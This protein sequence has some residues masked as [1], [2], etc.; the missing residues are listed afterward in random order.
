MK[1]TLCHLLIINSF[2]LFPSKA[3]ELPL[4]YILQYSQDFSKQTSIDDFNFSNPDSCKIAKGKNNYYLE[5]TGNNNYK[6]SVK[7][8]ENLCILSKYMFGDFIMEVDFLSEANENDSSDICIFIGVRDSLKYYYVSLSS[9]TYVNMHDIFIVNNAPQASIATNINEEV[10]WDNKK[11]NKA[12]IKRDILTRTITVYINDIS[13]PLIE[14]KDYTIVMGYIG[15]G[16]FKDPGKIDNI[17]I[18]APTAIPEE[19]NIFQNS[20]QQITNSK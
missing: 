14:A 5:I 9:N 20:N 16:T 1:N 12:I 3:Q 19:I 18:Y 8:P 4:G 11:W 2:L 6:P 15:F 10:K 13:N 7:S 17:K